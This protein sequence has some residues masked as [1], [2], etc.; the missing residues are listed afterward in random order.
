MQL[1]F[2]YMT[3]FSSF[4]IANSTENVLMLNFFVIRAGTFGGLLEYSAEKKVSEQSTV[5]AAVSVGVPTGV[6]LKLK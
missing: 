2:S 3:T 5:S 6:K 4:F 1:K